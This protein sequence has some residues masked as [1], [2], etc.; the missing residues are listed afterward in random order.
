MARGRPPGVV[1]PGSGRTDWLERR[2]ADTPPEL[3]ES[4]RGLCAGQ[5][6]PH[7]RDM[8]SRALD[9]FERIGCE[10]QTRAGALELLAADALLTYAFE[11]AADPE[12]GGT[13][14]RAISLAREL[15]PGGELG[16]RAGA[17]A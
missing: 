4:I 8:A 11:A 10:S 5:A 15:G 6:C 9:T 7:P 2:L 3:A 1:S 13:A 17:G 12:L 16:R 14:E